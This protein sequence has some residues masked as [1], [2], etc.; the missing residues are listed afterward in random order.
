[1][2][3]WPSGGLVVEDAMGKTTVEDADQTVSDGTQS[4]VVR[5]TAT[6]MIVVVTAYAW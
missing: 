1:M 4:L 3:S 2:W 6:P 5:L